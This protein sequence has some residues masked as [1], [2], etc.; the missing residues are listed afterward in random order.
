VAKDD[1]SV[2]P[3]GQELVISGEFKDTPAGRPRT[4]PRPPLRP[5]RVPG[6]AARPR[7]GGQVTAA[8]ADGVLMVTVPRA[9]TGK[10]RRI[11]ITGG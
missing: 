2:E 7:P 3:T 8:L 11:Q 10:P 1:I 5:V 6:A 4:A 9:E